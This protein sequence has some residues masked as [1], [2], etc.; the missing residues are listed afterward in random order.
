MKVKYDFLLNKRRYGVVEQ[1]IMQLVLCGCRSV[2]SIS[3]LLWVFTDEV[4]ASAIKNLVNSQILHASLS[5][6]ELFL[7]DALQAI[8]DACNNNIYEL[9]LPDILLSQA[10]DN[11]ILIKNSK[12]ILGILE[13]IV[14]GANLNYLGNSLWFSILV[15]GEM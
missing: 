1:L 4:K 5:A 8:I 3:D 6:Q 10:Q 15:E 9:D 7:P 2:P 13:Q 14:P 12:V 11:T